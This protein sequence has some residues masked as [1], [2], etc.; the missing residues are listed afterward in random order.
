MTGDSFH[1]VGHSLG[2]HLVVSARLL[3]RE[4]RNYPQ[5]NLTGHSG[6][7]LFDGNAGH[8]ESRKSNRLG[9]DSGWKGVDIMRVVSGLDPAGPRFVDGPFV[10]RIPELGD[11][12]LGEEDAAFVDV[13]H[14]NG[15]FEP[16][17]VCPN[18]E[19]SPV[20]AAPTLTVFSAR[21][22]HPAARAHGLLP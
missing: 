5:L 3:V 15:G 16:C 8:R 10:S 18:R 1:L 4:C 7:A 11:N 6:K 22:R 20:R 21:W 2:A 19:H 14:T 17:I 12:R 9:L 13:I